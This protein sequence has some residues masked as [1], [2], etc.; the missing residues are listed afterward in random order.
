MLRET[1]T[2]PSHDRYV[3]IRKH[4]L[5]GGT[6]PPMEGFFERIMMFASAA[7]LDNGLIVTS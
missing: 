1:A 6:L 3:F 5:G 4:R 7:P 2:H